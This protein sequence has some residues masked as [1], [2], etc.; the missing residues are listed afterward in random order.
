MPDSSRVEATQTTDHEEIR[1][2]VEERGGKPAVVKTTHREPGTGI[3]RVEFPDYPEAHDENLEPIS[4][5]EFFQIF[6][7]NNLAFLHQDRTA[8]GGISRFYK[9]VER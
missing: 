4:W 1:R 5:E 7:A 2:W 9:F 8:S 6:E 3:L